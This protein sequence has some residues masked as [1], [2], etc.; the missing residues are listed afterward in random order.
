MSSLKR[1]FLIATAFLFFLQFCRAVPPNG[2]VSFS[3]DTESATVW[4]LTGSYGFQQTIIGAG[5][6]ETP[7]GFGI[8]LRQDERGFLFGSGFTVVNVGN[9][10]VGASYVVRGKISGGGDNTRVTLNVRLSGEDIIT[11]INTRFGISLVYTLTVD[12]ASGT[13]QGL[14]RGRAKFSGLGSGKILSF[15]AASFP[16]SSGGT[17]TLQMNILPLSRLVGNAQIILPNGRILQ[18]RLGGVYSP[19]LDRSSVRVSGVGISR[20]NTV[21][22]TFDTDVLQ[23]QGRVLGQ[24]VTQVATVPETP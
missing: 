9:D 20:G 10:F 1:S 14:A 8:D 24:L 4:D 12:A 18:A 13:L 15:V 2:T 3:F 21:L 6:A 17:W 5:G 7:L 16:A 23:L 11:G 19:G 22:L